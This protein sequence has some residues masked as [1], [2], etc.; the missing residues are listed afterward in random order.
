M[1]SLSHAL[2]FLWWNLQDLA[3]FDVTRT[4]SPR[5]PKSREE[6]YEKRRRIEVALQFLSANDKPALLAFAEVTERAAHDLRD[7]LFPGYN[8]YS[9]ANLG[10]KTNSHIALIYDSTAGW[11]MKNY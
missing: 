3:H 4:A 2:N 6:Y 11:A 8:V 1:S 10:G 7:R 9:L 5:W